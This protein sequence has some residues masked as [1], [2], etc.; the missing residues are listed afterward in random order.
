MKFNDMNIEKSVLDSLNEM[1]FNEPTEI[2]KETIPLIKEGHDLIGQSKTGSGKT[3]AFGIPL[4]EKAKNTG[5]IQALIL[6][7][8]RELAEQTSNEL[9]KFSKFKRLHVLCVYGGV[10][11][12]HQITN[13]RHSDIVVGTPG[14]TL[15]HIQRGTMNLQNVNIFVLDEADKMFEMG[16][17]EDIERIAK[18]LPDVRQN[19]FFSATMTDE[20]LRIKNKFTKNAKKVKTETMLNEDVLEQFYYDVY[21]A[22]KFS[23][24]I[25]LLKSENPDL[26]IIFCNTRREAGCVAENLKRNGIVASCLHGGLT[27]ARRNQV[28][29]DFHDRRIKVLVATDVAG[30]GLDIKNVSHIFNYSVPKCPEDYINR[31]GRTARAGETGKAISLLSN[32]DHDCFRKLISMYSQ[33]IK[34]VDKPDFEVLPF[35]KDFASEG[36]PFYRQD[37]G[38]GLR[39]N[40]FRPRHSRY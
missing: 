10:S 6:E 38:H 35:R 12:E 39:R 8:T 15:D 27:Q 11:I 33:E 26:S 37:F 19:L 3:A 7:P 17:I 32:N 30:R 18:F 4:V 22:E 21:P 31:V 5:K 29:Q 1:G 40:G 13:L 34:R 25:H 9:K 20:V 16:F 14:R 2:Q 23:L 24:L 36:R 28:I